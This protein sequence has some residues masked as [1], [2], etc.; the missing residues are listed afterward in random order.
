MAINFRADDVRDVC[1]RV[2]MI[3]YLTVC[4]R[5]GALVDLRRIAR[6]RIKEM[7]TIS[8]ARTQSEGGNRLV[9]AVDRRHFAYY[10]NAGISLPAAM[11]I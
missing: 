2:V 10:I 3:C 1:Q 6:E 8:E 4:H 7:P 5:R 9:R 11:F